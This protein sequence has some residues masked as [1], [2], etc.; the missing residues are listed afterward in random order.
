MPRYHNIN[1]V[2]VQFTSDEETA[3]DAEEAAVAAAEPASKWASVR[4]KRDALLSSCDWMA[5]SDV[6][7]SD[8]WK[9][10]RQDL[11]N[12]PASQSDPDDIVFPKKPS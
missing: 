12:L 2:D 6:T 5:T 7:M 9:A 8:A 4:S 10:Y 1:G 11:R 3:R